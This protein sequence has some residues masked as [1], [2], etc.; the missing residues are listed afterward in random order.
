M[1]IANLMWV[2]THQ[3]LWFARIDTLNDE[4]EGLYPDLQRKETEIGITRLREQMESIPGFP[5][6]EIDRHVSYYTSKLSEN[7]AW[8]P[9]DDLRQCAYTNCWYLSEYESMGM[10]RA[11]SNPEGVV[12]RSTFKRIKDA[13]TLSPE[14]IYIGRVHYIDYETGRVDPSNLLKRFLHKRKPFEYEHEL[15]ALHWNINSL[16][17]DGER[18]PT[19]TAIRVD[20]AGLIEAIVLHPAA[21]E[22]LPST[23]KDVVAK[24]AYAPEVRTSEI[25]REPYKLR[26]ET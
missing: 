2:L 21:P 17:G 1:S 14:P 8:D 16:I 12:V 22:W 19:G 25:A 4:R 24:Y 20:V 11:Y 18:A 23:L 26:V 15:R 10:W 13:L 7:P 9:S 6:E 5:K 3:S